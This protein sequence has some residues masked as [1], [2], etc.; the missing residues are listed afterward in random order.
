[1]LLKMTIITFVIRKRINTKWVSG[2]GINKHKI[3]KRP[4]D[5]LK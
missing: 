5:T 2:K 1:M 4:E 3:E